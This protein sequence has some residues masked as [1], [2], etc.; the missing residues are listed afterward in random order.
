MNLKVLRFFL[1]IWKILSAANISL[2]LHTHV[3]HVSTYF[4]GASVLTYSSSQSW[5]HAVSRVHKHATNIC[6]RN[7]EQLGS[8]KFELAFPHADMLIV[9]C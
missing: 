3:S 1:K 8:Y 7:S 2:S 9:F 5:L 4:G 6:L